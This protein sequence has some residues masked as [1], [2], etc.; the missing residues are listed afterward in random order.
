MHFLVDKGECP[1]SG[2]RRLKHDG[3]SNINTV[4]T[5]RA[6]PTLTAWFY[7]L[8]TIY[9][10]DAHQL[11]VLFEYVSFFGECMHMF[12]STN[13]NNDEVLPIGFSRVPFSK[14]VPSF[15]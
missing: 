1:L 13:D 15:S 2:A 8:F 12:V 6:L 7:H 11:I 10:Y 3:Y 5:H 4:N 14:L 9:Y